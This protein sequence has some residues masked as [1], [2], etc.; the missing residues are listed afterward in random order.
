M[1]INII[2]ENIKK[3]KFY[4]VILIILNVIFFLLSIYQFKINKNKF[5]IDKFFIANTLLNIVVLVITYKVFKKFKF[6]QFQFKYFSL[7]NN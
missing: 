6:Y 3:F 4:L 1:D 2:I 5:I 7:N